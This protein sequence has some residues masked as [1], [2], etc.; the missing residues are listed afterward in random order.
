MFI[1]EEHAAGMPEK[2]EQQERWTCQLRGPPFLCVFLPR[3]PQ[4]PGWCLPPWV[5]ARVSTQFWLLMS[6]WDTSQTHPEVMLYQLSSV[7]HAA[8]D[9][10][11]PDPPWWFPSWLFRVMWTHSVQRG[12]HRPEW[13]WTAPGSRGLTPTMCFP[14][15]ST[16]SSP[17]LFSPPGGFILLKRFLHCS[18]RESWGW[19]NIR[20]MCSVSCLHPEMWIGFMV[21]INS[22]ILN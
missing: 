4:W 22:F 5:K 3:G 6:P 21:L 12:G 2:Q 15:S 11:C 13:R 17:L 16:L 8:R 7:P 14:P 10:V 19:S 1:E 20:P 18:Y 9:R